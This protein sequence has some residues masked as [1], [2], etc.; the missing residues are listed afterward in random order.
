SHIIERTRDEAGNY[1]CQ[2]A[3]RQRA[4]T[5]WYAR[6]IWFWL[7]LEFLQ[8]PFPHVA[9]RRDRRFSYQHSTFLERQANHYRALQSGRCKSGKP[10]SQGCGPVHWRAALNMAVG[11]KV[12][13]QSD[14]REE[15]EA[16]DAHVRRDR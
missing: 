6:R 5:G 1:S 13:A 12:G 14:T 8:R 11:F 4:G 10:G 16:R 9:L 3:G 2:S 7:V 15:T